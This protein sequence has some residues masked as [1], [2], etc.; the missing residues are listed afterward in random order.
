MDGSATTTPCPTPERATTARRPDSVRGEPAIVGQCPGLR[1]VL[2]AADR[3]APTAMSVL[4]TGE[5]GTGKEGLARRLH[6]MSGRKGAFVVVN[7][8]SLP[9]ELVESELFGH[10]RGAFT[11]AV[12]DK[13]GLVLDANG[14]TLFLDEIG[15][16][17]ME[18]QAKLLRLLQ[19]KE[20]RPLGGRQVIKV[21]VRVVAAT[22][23]DLRARVADGAFRE[24]LLYRLAVFELALPPLRER[25]D[26]VLLLARHVV[27]GFVRQPGIGRRS[28]AR[29]A[30]AALRGH[31]WKGNVR[32]LQAVLARA[33]VLGD[34]RTITGADIRAALPV[35][36]AA[37]ASV[38]ERLLTLI[39]SAGEVTMGQIM[40]A[41]RVPRTTAWRVV[42]GLVAGGKVAATGTTKG[43][44][45]STAA[46]V[47]LP[48][49]AS[50]ADPRWDLILA[51]VRAEGRVNRQGVVERLGLPERDC[52]T[53]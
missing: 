35:A 33:A 53:P 14:G 23:R 45:Y 31:E 44:K 6:D 38:D 3:I 29:S 20:I 27:D 39:G 10:A 21:D 32:E 8:A 28:L 50:T 17:T 40:V 19:E 42:T 12:G 2:A 47:A 16:L 22:W 52:S 26:D 9:P 43:R 30:G 24:D 49:P 25:G 4:V 13:R 11:G 37:E 36:P 5:T 1:R 18:V 34:G 7:C 46:T 15:E 41:L 51:L 48:A